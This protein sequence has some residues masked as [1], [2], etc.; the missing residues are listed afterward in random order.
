MAQ[1]DLKVEGRK[2]IVLVGKEYFENLA[3]HSLFQDFETNHAY[4]EIRS[5]KMHD[6]AHDHFAQFLAKNECLTID[7]DDPI[8]SDQLEFGS[9]RARHSML[10]LSR[11][12]KFL[13][14]KFDKIA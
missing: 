13:S 11:D 12:G 6:I 3:M 4:G 9:H 7:V 2:D 10:R 14:L 1:G 8:V 5:C